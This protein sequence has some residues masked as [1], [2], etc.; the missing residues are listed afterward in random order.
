MSIVS[1]LVISMNDS[2]NFDGLVYVD[3]YENVVNLERIEDDMG[4][5]LFLLFLFLWVV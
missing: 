5:S 3:K 4:A 2:F 1:A